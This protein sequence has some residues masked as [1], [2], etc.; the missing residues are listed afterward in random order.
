MRVFV[1]IR[2]SGI[3]RI[4]PAQL[5]LFAI[6]ANPANANADERLPIEDEPDE[7]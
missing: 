2:I 6:T 7:S 3:F 4:S 5:A 1:R